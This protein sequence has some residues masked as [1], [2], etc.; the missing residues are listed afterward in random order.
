MSWAGRCRGWLVKAAKQS[1]RRALELG[2]SIMSWP[3]IPCRRGKDA[4]LSRLLSLFRVWRTMKLHY[5]LESARHRR[6][7]DLHIVVGIP[8]LLRWTAR[9]SPPR[10]TVSRPRKAK[11]LAHELPANDAAAVQVE[12]DLSALLFHPFR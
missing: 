12:R 5:L 3:G 9:S 1:Y 8:P 2:V 10:A 7:S 11:M 4:L 6:A